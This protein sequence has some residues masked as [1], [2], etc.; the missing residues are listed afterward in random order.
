MANRQVKCCSPSLL[1]KETQ[2]GTTMR[3]HLIPVRVAV[4][5]TKN[6]KYSREYGE[7]GPSS[8]VGGILNLCSHHGKKSRSFSKNITELPCDTAVPLL[9]ICLKKTKPLI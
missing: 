4:L 8:T 9:G 5:K 2:I 6:K 3:Y 7:R 1:I